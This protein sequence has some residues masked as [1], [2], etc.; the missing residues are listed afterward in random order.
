MTLALSGG[1][2][3]PVRSRSAQHLALWHFLEQ[4]LRGS[5]ICLLAIFLCALHTSAFVCM[6]TNALHSS[7]PMQQLLLHNAQAAGSLRS[8]GCLVLFPYLRVQSLFT[9]PCTRPCI[10]RHTDFTFLGRHFT[11]LSPAEN[12]AWYFSTR[13]RPSSEFMSPAATHKHQVARA[14]SCTQ[15]HTTNS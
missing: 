6:R 12:R 7:A 13:A 1:Q 9:L 5:A 14:T 8:A 4:G 15:C 2:T 10:T 3:G 11:C